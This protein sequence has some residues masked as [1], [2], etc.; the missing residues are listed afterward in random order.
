MDDTSAP[1]GRQGLPEHD[2]RPVSL[3]VL[4]L[5]NLLCGDDGLG[6]AAVARL[7]RDWEA[8]DGAL[9]LDGGTLGLALLPYLEDARDVILVDAIR[10]DG[11]PGALVL[12]AGEDVAPAVRHRLS[13]HQIGVADLLDGARLHDRYP[14]RLVLVGLV[15]ATLSLGIERSAAVQSHLPELVHEIVAQ[16]RRLD[17]AFV[18]RTNR[19]SDSRDHGHVARVFGL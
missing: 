4:G 5:G 2:P 8:P 7:D 3:L 1:L 12:L 13:P 17:H 9:V 19:P 18:R 15:P 14:R 10:A 6:A 16:A 11:P